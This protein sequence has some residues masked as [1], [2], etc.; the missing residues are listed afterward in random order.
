MAKAN[1][2][3]NSG[4]VVTLATGQTYT[5]KS[6]EVFLNEVIYKKVDLEISL[7]NN[8]ITATPA[9]VLIGIT[10]RDGRRNLPAHYVRFDDWF[11]DGVQQ[12]TLT[13]CVANITAVIFSSLGSSTVVAQQVNQFSDL[14][15]GNNIGDLA[16]VENSEGTAW[17]PATLGGSYYPAGWYIWDGVTW[18]SDRNAIANQLKLLIDD[19]T[20][21]QGVLTTKGDLFTFDTAYQRLGVGT[22]GQSLVADSGE[23]TGLKWDTPAGGGDMLL[24]G[25]QTVTGAK[26]FNDG[27][28]L[29]DDSDSAFNL[30][31]KSTSTITTAD[32]TLTLDVNDA[33]RTLII[34]GDATVSGINLGDQAFSNASDATT[35][36][37]TLSASGGSI[38][39]V[40]GSNITLTTT[41]T[42]LD[43]IVTIAST[44]GGGSVATDV[45]W[46][47]AGDL[48]VG[49]GADTAVRL[50]IG[51][52]NQI[53]QVNGGAT[54]I[55]YTSAPTNLTSIGLNDTDSA[56][57][58]LIQSTSTITTADKTLTL[59][60]N[61]Q[62]TTLILTSATASLEGINTGDQSTIVGITGTKAQFDTAVTDG[63]ILYVGDAV[64]DV[65]GGVGIG[66]TGG[67]TPS[68]TLDVSELSVST[69]VTGDWIV[70]DNAGA[71]NKALISA[72][73]LGIFNNDQSWNNYSHPNHTGDV[74][75]TGDGATVISVDAVD[76][77]MLSA[78]GTPTASN[79]LRGD[80]TWA[81]P[82][83]SGDMILADPQTVTGAKTFDAGT[84]LLNDT[85]SIF[86]LELG[87][88]STITGAN[89]TLTFDVN[90]SNRTLTISGD[91]T[92]S[93]SNL[94]DETQSSI[95]A[96]AITTVGTIASGTWEG[97]DIASGFIADTLT[98]KALTG[99]TLSLNDT[100]SAFNLVVQSTST[101]TSADKTLTIDV[102]DSNRTL[103]ISGDAT[104][105]GSNLG[106]E[107]QSSINSLAI[108]EVGT[109]TTGTWSATDIAVSAG[110]TGLS[111]I[112]AG[113]VW[114]ANALD[115]IIAITSTSGTRVLTN[116]AG[117]ITWEVSAGGGDVTKVGTPVNNQI[118]QWTGD[119]TIQGTADLTYDETTQLMTIGDA[120]GSP[121]IR[122]D[123]DELLT[124]GIEFY[125]EGVLS[126][127]IKEIA[128]ERLQLDTPA[129]GEF[130]IGGTLKYRWSSLTFA[131]TASTGFN[132]LQTGGT[133]TAPIYRRSASTVDG[134]STATGNVCTVVSNSKVGLLTID[135]GTGTNVEI[136][137]NVKSFGASTAG[138]GVL[139]LNDVV[140]TPA[141][142]MA[143]G[144]LIYV[145]GTSLNFM[146]DAGTIT[147][148][149]TAGGGD[150]TKVGTPVDSQIGVWTGD[151]TIEGTTKFLW[152]DTANLMTI[153]DATVSPEVRILKDEAGTS[154]ISFYNEGVEEAYI[155]QGAT[156]I[157]VIS[158]LTSGRL[159]SLGVD[160]WSWDGTEFK[161]FTAGGGSLRQAG[162][163]L[164]T[165]YAY[166]SGTTSSGIGG[167]VSSNVA[168]VSNA[169]S[170]LVAS[171][172]GT[173]NNIELF[174]SSALFGATIG[175]EGVLRL[176]DV[177]TI[178]T[179]TMTSGG[180]LYVT[181]TSL[182]FLADDGV[183]T[184][185]TASGGGDMILASAQTVT[186]A[187]T[188]DAGT[189]LLNDTDSAFDL[190]LG[191]TSTITGANKTLTFDVNDQ[192]TTLILTSTTASLEGTN[193]G[194]ETLSSINALA[195]T[196]V[197][198]IDTGT[199][200][201]TAI[202]TGFIAT[203]LTGKTLTGATLS[204]NDTDSSFNL[205]VQST[206]TLTTDR[207]LTI[208]TNDSAVTLTIG[209]ST[210]LSGGT[211]SGTNSG[212]E[213][214][215]SIN[216]LAITTVG[217]ID[218][219]TWEG[220]VVAT[221]FIATTLTGKTLTG[222]T[223]SLNDTDSSFDLT[224]Q[225]TSTL[226]ADR[227]LTIDVNDSA[228]TLTISG[229]ATISGSNLGDQT[230]VLTFG[231]GLAG[232]NYDPDTA[233]TIS[234][235]FSELTDMTGAV[236]GTTEM[237]LQDGAT[238]SRKALSEVDLS[239][240]NEDRQFE[241]SFSIE[242]PT[243]TDVI[244]LWSPD[245]AITLVKIRTWI[246]GGTSV[247]FNISHNT[248]PT[249]TTDWFT[250]DKV[251]NTL[252]TV[253]VHSGSVNDDTVAIGE[254][255]NYMASALSGSV[256]ML[257]LT[258]Y[259]TKD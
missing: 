133:E 5:L 77:A 246:V 43:G 173:T 125:K 150:V 166:R 111:T 69:M 191:S 256:T 201:G 232:T 100:D 93:G 239:A 14:V 259:Y 249:T 79:F 63:N 19:V 112:P 8:S 101:I 153:G 196:T 224:V 136:N 52:A 144:G 219:G 200:E 247:D 45:I 189:L 180:L 46:D 73:P 104:V 127:S 245:E 202:A 123:K 44:G 157:L 231:V 105:S 198:T 206:S 94:G 212:D 114:G 62:N 243:A 41:G 147:D 164:V 162:G 205:T 32:K 12:T 197:G 38:Q 151:G 240:F 167:D 66:S 185:L 102:N 35:H 131:S 110:G 209:V 174:G 138:E 54:N 30:V 97:T 229:D 252:T 28:L 3:F 215:S 181:G 154:K 186:G 96:L 182:H 134:F 210:T 33:N 176:N 217:T 99:A 203:T 75:S 132:V 137:G 11:I 170:A 159:A 34:S 192:N 233:T 50:G 40:E 72:I 193:T 204:L 187:K 165:P 10:K 83:G 126:S 17:L 251:A 139:R 143:S 140:T 158:T 221:G 169:K 146:D 116:T 141:G 61:D 109:I 89:K 130:F 178:P 255:I 155:E 67:T 115:T 168:I 47:S 2:L 199:W 95:N 220:T 82:A 42:G 106:D 188:F 113:S 242:D 184:D 31:I 161:S 58:L 248:N 90:D 253:Q 88:T 15:A 78:T 195:I 92:V 121:I 76:L 59:D 156:E 80:N 230:A 194:D 16:Y 234:L 55:E 145:S 24:A 160:K 223:L 68:I 27:T 4:Q 183:D 26:T 91:A 207:I 49:S 118:G 13:L 190:E 9:D 257:H 71:S 60:V 225:S 238:E 149:T 18:E 172:Q 87:S 148:L 250:A 218:A 25:V 216:A 135:A 214:L 213:T 84:L 86:D 37:L 74:T 211:H 7:Q 20:A 29:L 177:T 39:L 107:T 48:A 124:S 236:S 64:T 227:I 208:D 152:D 119:G 258:I 175:G 51:T 108:T 222:A 22:D 122:L 254:A 85:D 129:N 98:G 6:D 70:F 103:T 53:L 23:A 179:G 241:K 128:S 21:L 81:T 120:T 65:T 36:T 1:N 57:N 244:P 163:S 226:T 237:I 228:R 56:F 235:D 142:T 117:T 171:N